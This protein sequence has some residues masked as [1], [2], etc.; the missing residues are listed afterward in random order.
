MVHNAD[1][2]IAEACRITKAIIKEYTV[3]P[4]FMSQTAGA[5]QWIIEFE[6]L[7]SD[8]EYFTYILDNTLK[9]K[10]SDYEA[11]RYND[12]V[13]SK[14]QIVIAP[15]NTFYQ[16]LKKHN[17]LGGQNKVPRLSNN[18]N[19]VEELLQIINEIKSNT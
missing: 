8:I 11:K 15:Q 16:W 4:I 19:F 18:R 13:L 3:A 6:K 5:H 17:K 2:A 14:P 1:E 9:E 10:N 12:Y 7:P